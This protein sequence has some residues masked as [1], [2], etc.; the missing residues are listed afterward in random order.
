MAARTCIGGEGSEVGMSQAGDVVLVVDDEEE[1]RVLIR[2][3]LERVGY[4]VVDAGG[5]L[6]ALRA[7]YERRPQLVILDLLMPEF[8]GLEVLDRIR[9]ISEVPVLILSARALEWERASGL[10]R[11]AD[12]YL[13]KPFALI[14]LTARVEAL[15]RRVRTRSEDEPVVYEDELLRVDHAERGVTVRGVPIQLTPLEYRLLIAFARHRGAVLERERILELVWGGTAGVDSAQVKVVVGHL[16]RK[17]GDRDDGTSPIETI[18][19]FGYVYRPETTPGAPA[20]TDRPGVL[21]A[22]WPLAARSSLKAEADPPG[23]RDSIPPPLRG[24]RGR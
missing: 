9:E 2:R 15:L 23:A 21:R 1:I 14:E 19:G 11:G 18:R 12:D 4:E 10:R 6:D 17:I 13:V 16:R 3:T 8:D 5:G 7:F 24:R 20:V 22:K